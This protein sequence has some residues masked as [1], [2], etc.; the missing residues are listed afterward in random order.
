MALRERIEKA[1]EKEG[2]GGK[3]CKERE[4]QSVTTMALAMPH[5]CSV[6]KWCAG[7]ASMDKGVTLVFGEQCGSCAL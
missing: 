4:T 6:S 7:T 3:G 5:R 1:E 2:K